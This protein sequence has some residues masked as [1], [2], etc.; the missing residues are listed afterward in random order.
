MPSSVRL[1]PSGQLEIVWMRGLGV[2]HGRPTQ[3]PE[4][5]SY[6]EYLE[7]CLPGKAKEQST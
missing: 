4:L 2:D 1:A 5:M 6:L 3:K 7:Q